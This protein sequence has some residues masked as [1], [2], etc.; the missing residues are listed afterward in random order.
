MLADAE[1]ELGDL[2]RG[3]GLDQLARAALG[4]DQALVHDDQPV[5]ELLGLVHVVGGD[6]QR[7][8][9]LLEPEQLVPQHVAGLRVE[10]GGGLVEQQQVGAVDQAA[11]DR[12]PALHAAG[13]VLDPGLRLVGERDELEQLVDARR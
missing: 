12:E 3:V 4:D 13:E 1:P 5:A 2:A 10:A 9:G 6:H 11:G 7:D 8:A